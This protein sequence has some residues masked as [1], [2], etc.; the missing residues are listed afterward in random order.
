MADIPWLPVARPRLPT[1]D[2]LMPYLRRIDESR[3]YANRGA[4]QVELEQRLEAM[5]GLPGQRVL[6]CASGTA[7]LIG[8]MLTVASGLKETRPLCLMPGFGFVATAAAA[9]LAGFAPHFADVSPRTGALCPERLM[10]HPRLSEVRM[11][12]PVVPF[13][14]RIDLAAW[15]RFAQQTGIAVVVDAAAGF[16]WLTAP[17]REFPPSLMIAVS[18]HATKAFAS[19]EGGLVIAADPDKARGAFQAINHGFLN[20][21]Q[22]ELLATNGKMSEYHAAVALAE[23]DGWAKKRAA[24][25]RTG[26]LLQAQ[27]RRRPREGRLWTCPDVAGCYALYQ[28]PTAAAAQAAQ[29]ALAAAQIG[30]RFW[31]GSGIQDHPAH[32]HLPS[33]DLTVARDLAGRL[34]GLPAFPDMTA[35]EA[36]RIIEALP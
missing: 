24:H 9:R 34:L 8:A 18:L 30:T 17:G 31:Y 12:V 23:L 26:A 28:A 32:R 10:S 7:A 20:T 27:W 6:A 25:R 15:D 36:T 21:R 29:K 16:E 22:A 2:R 14:R 35:A 5:T 19:G 4:L 3:V 13:G 11:V 33:D 1:A